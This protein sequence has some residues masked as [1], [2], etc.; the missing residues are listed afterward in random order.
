MLVYL[1]W[2]ELLSQCTAEKVPKQSNFQ[3]KV[4]VLYKGIPGEKMDVY[5]F[6]S[7][8]IPFG[9]TNVTWVYVLRSHLW[10]E[11]KCE[12]HYKLFTLR[13]HI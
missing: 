11:H 9:I 1:S 3:S 4:S 12:E 8:S 7:V 10:P 6:W 5:L 13:I 2:C